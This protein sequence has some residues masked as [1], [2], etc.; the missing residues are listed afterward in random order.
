MNFNKSIMPLGAAI[1][2]AA[3]GQPASSQTGGAAEDAATVQDFGAISGTYKSE[4]RHRYI[5]FNYDHFGYSRPQIRWR[6]W[7]ATLEWNAE[8]PAASSVSVT[9]D[10]TSADSGV[11]V[12]DGHLTGERFFD[13]ENFDEITFVS[14]GIVRTG[15]TTGKITGDLT[16]KDVTKSVT[17]DATFNKGSFDE[18][19]NLYK[20]G[21]SATAAVN[22]SEFGLDY[23][24]PAVSDQV[25]IVIS[26]EFIMPV[27]AAE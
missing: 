17:L 16:I 21:F 23:A 12:F 11:D 2:L 3:C 8:D 22:R 14:T 10:A 15:E 9:I 1:A 25:N 26:A 19:G 5:T 7:D 6:E 4:E 27:D 13:T 18:R 24:V 20:I